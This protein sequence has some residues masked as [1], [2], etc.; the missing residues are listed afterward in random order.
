MRLLSDNG[1]IQRVDGQSGFG[2]VLKTYSDGYDYIW[3]ETPLRL[4]AAGHNFI[5][6]LRQKDVWETI[7]TNFRDEGVSTLVSLSRQLAEAFAKKKIKEIIGL[8]I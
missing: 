4:T 2:H 6:D 1:L 8:E 3:I 5:A 7:K